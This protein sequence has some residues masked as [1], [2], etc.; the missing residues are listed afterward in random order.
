MSVSIRRH[1]EHGPLN[2]LKKL[3][4]ADREKNFLSTIVEFYPL[5]RGIDKHNGKKPNRKEYK[6][7][8][9]IL[10]IH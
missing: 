9:K 5:L 4:S 3:F 6:Y 7:I 2:L 10:F 8:M 1:D